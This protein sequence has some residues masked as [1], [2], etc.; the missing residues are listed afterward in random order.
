MDQPGKVANPACPR[1][2]LRIFGLARQVPPSRPA[3]ACSFSIYSGWIWCLLAGFRSISAAAVHLLFKPPYV[4]GSVPSSSGHA[5]IA[6]R[7]RSLPT[8]HRHRASSPQGSSSSKRVLPLPH[9]GPINMRLYYPAPTTNDM[10]WCYSILKL[11]VGWGL[12]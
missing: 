8:V 11:S 2:R 3:S 10:K 7:W 6:Y 12:P 5:I 1:S 9:H 4:I